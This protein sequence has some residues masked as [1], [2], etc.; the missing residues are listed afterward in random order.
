MNRATRTIATVFTGVLAATGGLLPALFFSAFVMVASPVH[1]WD[2]RG[3]SA[4]RDQDSQTGNADVAALAEYGRQIAVQSAKSG[5]GSAPGNDDPHFADRDFAALRDYAREVVK[6]QPAAATGDDAGWAHP[7]VDGKEVAVRRAPSVSGQGQGHAHLADP[8]IAA[9]RDY[10]R[11]VGAESDGSFQVAEAD[12]AFDA[13]RDLL[14]K[15][16]EPS[17][18]PPVKPQTGPARPV[19]P[20]IKPS[21]SF[22]DARRLGAQTCLF[23]HAVQ[24]ESFGRTLMGRVAKTQPA[25]LDCENCHGPGS[26]HVQAVGCGPCHGDDGISKRPGI[27]SLV[28]QD[29]QYLVP[30]LKAYA[31]GQ[32]KHDLMRLVASGLSDGEMRNLAAFYARVAPVRA[33]TPPVGDASAGRA[34]TGLCAECHGN[35]GISVA[36]G[37]PSLAGQDAQYLADAIHAY[38]VGS[39][40]KAV[41]CGACHGES[42]ISRKPGIPNLAGLSPQYLGQAMKAYAG[43]KRKNGVM[44]ALLSG[45][46]DAQLNGMAA[47]YAQQPPAQAQ[48]QAVGNS[49]A[50]KT[51]AVLCVQC[52]GEATG[53][54]SDAVPNL[55]GQDARYLA[56]SIKAYKNDARQK[57]IACADCHGE[58]GVAAR[59]GVPNLAGQSQQYLVMALKDYATGKRQGSVMTALMSGVDDAQI[60]S[61]AQFY[62]RQSPAQAQSLAQGPAVGN[63]AA[64]KTAATLCIGCHGDGAGTVSDLVPNLAGQDA[65]YLSAA[66]KAFKNDTRHKIVACASCHGERGISSKPGVPN[67]AGQSPQYLAG[68][69]K[70]YAGGRRKHA[71]MNALLAAANEADFND[72]ARYYA[73]QVPARANTP[74][75]GDAA[76]GKAISVPC[77]GCHGQQGIAVSPIPSLAA[78]D[79]R[80]IS[81][82]LHAYKS[83]SRTHAIMSPITRGL[84][85]TAINNLAGYYSSLPPATAPLDI[86]PAPAGSREPEVMANKMLAPLDDRTA[87]DIASFY[88]SLARARPAQTSATGSEPQLVV[89][90]MLASLDDKTMDDIAGYFAGLVPARTGQPGGRSANRGEPVVVRNGLVAALNDQ[91]MRNVG[92]YY[93][94]LMPAQPASAGREFRGP[95]PAQ[96]SYTRAADGSSPG[97]IV[98]FRKNDPSRR[99]EQNNAICLTCHERGDRTYWNGSTHEVRG[100]ACTECHTVMRPVSRKFALKTEIEMETCFQCHKDRRAQIFRSA[101]M[102]LREGKLTCSNCHNTHGS[103]TEAMLKENSI[104]DTCYKCHAEKRGPFLFEHA[105][106]RENC[107]SCHD[108]HGSSTEY[109]LKV[110]RPRLCAEC[111]GMGHG[112]T[113]KGP[114]QIETMGRSCQNCHTMVHGSNSPSGALL[115]R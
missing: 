21:V 38:K 45:V 90:K 87:D 65:R 110:S 80:Y 18:H 13:L 64:G 67:L 50:G 115:Q 53:S 35:L 70:E 104:N 10:A 68:E 49:A 59:P 12:N 40:Q 32:R 14:R 1:A 105:P 95:V 57:V 58:R 114:G 85:D 47:Y 27:P 94:S 23:C 39:R 79:A 76:T 30:A 48:T 42:G 6:A 43:G 113:A 37:I 34:S 19:P 84:D 103:A 73:R 2:M 36:P 15:K 99:V 22:V 102:P 8:E 106:V 17:P 4:A 61:L 86:T 29:P 71:V 88:A 33:L 52:H 51:A 28:G 69:M 55:A 89:N 91:A 9:L 92:S 81:D 63:A 7:A 98:S 31:T 101:H 26:T 72:I 54:L 75:L 77:A 3:A 5:A 62:S 112:S 11:E 20:S 109:M 56:A 93:A 44:N 107:L 41:P 24:A 83:G 46:D 66:I 96:V 78:Q 60:N 82:A 111:H 25:K 100:V 74:A 97:G 16:N 108:P